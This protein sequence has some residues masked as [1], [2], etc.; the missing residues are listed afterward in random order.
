MFIGRTIKR[1]ALLLQGVWKRL[2]TLRQKFV[3]ER[4]TISR[5]LT[6]RN[7]IE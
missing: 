3:A 2:L 6:I 1:N 5:F 7:S 4:C